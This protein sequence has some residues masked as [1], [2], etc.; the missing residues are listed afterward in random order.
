MADRT[1]IRRP[2]GQLLQTRRNIEKT[3]PRHSLPPVESITI[4]HRHPD[5]P[6]RIDQLVIGNT[7]DI[8]EDHHPEPYQG[9][10]FTKIVE[11]G[12]YSK[13]TKPYEFRKGKI[14]LILP[15]NYL[16]NTCK[17][18]ESSSSMPAIGI[19]NT[20]GGSRHKRRRRSNKSRKS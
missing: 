3:L 10:V 8:F 2:L 6:L 9:F 18:F 13:F 7:Y 16:S 19:I 14:S 5:M 4:S 17:I 1:N 20:R 11:S 15:E 12:G